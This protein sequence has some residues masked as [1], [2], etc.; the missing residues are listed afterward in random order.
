MS[1]GSPPIPPSPGIEYCCIL[2]EDVEVAQGRHGPGD[3]GRNLADQKTRAD[4]P[5][6]G[7]AKTGIEK[8]KVFED[9]LKAIKYPMEIRA[10]AWSPSGD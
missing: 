5:A 6:S 2:S 3:D 4:D 7:L 8:K 9:C 1:R 10:C